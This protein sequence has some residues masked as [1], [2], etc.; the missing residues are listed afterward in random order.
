MIDVANKYKCGNFQ[1]STLSTGPTGEP[2]TTA[3]LTVN[4]EKLNEIY[5]KLKVYD[6]DF[7]TFC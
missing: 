1:N 4:K 6:N 7:L 2:N 5:C 3:V